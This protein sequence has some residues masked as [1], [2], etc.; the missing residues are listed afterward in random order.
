MP[1]EPIGKSKQQPVE[2]GVVFRSAGDDMNKRPCRDS[3]EFLLVAQDGDP[4]AVQ[5]LF[6]VVYDELKSIAHRHWNPIHLPGISHQPIW[7]MKFI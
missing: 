2:F 7:F 4:S 5:K 3:T 1:I 6:P